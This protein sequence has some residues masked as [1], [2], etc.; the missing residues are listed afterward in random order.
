MFDGDAVIGGP[1]RGIV[2][3]IVLCGKARIDRSAV[4]LLRGCVRFH[5]TVRSFPRG[6]EILDRSRG[7]ELRFFHVQFP[8]P[9][10]IVSRKGSDGGNRHADHELCHNVS[11][12]CFLSTGITAPVADSIPLARK[13]IGAKRIGGATRITIASVAWLS[14]VSNAATINH[15][16]H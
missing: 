14:A 5:A 7:A 11:H 9:E 15:R 4:G 8:C 10:R 3:A 13:Y 2:L 1:S 16:I 12:S 6:G